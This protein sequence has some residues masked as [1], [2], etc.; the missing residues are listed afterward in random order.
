MNEKIIYVIKIK[1]VEKPLTYKFTYLD[2]CALEFDKNGKFILTVK[3]GK[4]NM[5]LVLC[6]YDKLE[7][8]YQSYE[9]DLEN[10]D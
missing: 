4:K 2:D 6:D 8:Y 10:N 5:L 9:C 1:D 3:I 7:Y